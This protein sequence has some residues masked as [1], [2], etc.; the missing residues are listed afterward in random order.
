MEAREDEEGAEATAESEEGGR[1]PE[2]AED[3][4]EGGGREEDDSEDRGRTE[5][6]GICVAADPGG[7]AT[8]FLSI[9]ATT[10]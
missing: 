4:E 8:C 6:R 3:E 2:N 9:G 7:S 5:E 1:E 10:Q